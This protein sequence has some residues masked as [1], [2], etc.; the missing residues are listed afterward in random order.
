[1]GVD[2]GQSTDPTAIAVLHHRV[3]PLDS[4]KPNDKAQTWKQDRTEHFDVKSRVGFP[5][6]ASAH[7]I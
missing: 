2:L 3:I 5:D 1:M 4:W 7:P 6:L